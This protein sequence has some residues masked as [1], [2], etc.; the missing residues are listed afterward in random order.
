M[1][2]GNHVR[3]D[4]DILNFGRVSLS[5]NIFVIIKFKIHH[6]I[7]SFKTLQLFGLYFLSNVFYYL[8]ID[9]LYTY[10]YV[11]CKQ[12]ISCKDGEQVIA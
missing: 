11:I 7:S 6:S 3:Q 1:F 9:I 12:K 5:V 4:Y 2:S 8:I 10:T